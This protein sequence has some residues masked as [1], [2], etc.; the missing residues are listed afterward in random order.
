MS[1]N[2]ICVDVT[3][4]VGFTGKVS[5]LALELIGYCESEN[6][7]EILA[8]LISTVNLAETDEEMENAFDVLY[9]VASDEGIDITEDLHQPDVYYFE[10]AAT[11]SGNLSYEVVL[12]NNG[13]S[14]CRVELLTESGVFKVAYPVILSDAQLDILLG[15]GKFSPT[16]KSFK[17]TNPETHEAVAALNT[18]IID[19]LEEN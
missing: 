3:N 4:E 1:E 6:S 12:D 19:L 9:E 16:G 5:A 15:L 13:A 7:T 10:L 2:F 18:Q 11:K 14:L 8:R 17:G